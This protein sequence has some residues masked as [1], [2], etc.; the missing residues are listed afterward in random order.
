MA[1]I[2]RGSDVHVGVALAFPYGAQTTRAKEAEIHEALE[3]GGPPW[4]WS[5]TSAR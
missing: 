5:S 2:L 1:E 4:T 3:V